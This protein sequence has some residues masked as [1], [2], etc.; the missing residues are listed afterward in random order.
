MGNVFKFITDTVSAPF[1]GLGDMVKGPM[2]D[3]PK[4]AEVVTP[5]APAKAA[6]GSEG[7][8]DMGI[9]KTGAALSRKARGKRGLMI[10]TAGS[11]GSSSGTG[12]NV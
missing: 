7:K 9:D 5:A 2:P 10:P 3:A 1:R 6:P 4:A 11:G 12:L 8:M